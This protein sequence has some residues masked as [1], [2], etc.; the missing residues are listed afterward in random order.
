M[1]KKAKIFIILGLTLLLTG[2]TKSFTADKKVY[3][4]NILCLPEKAETLKIYDDNKIDISKLSS[5]DEFSVSNTNY[6][7]VW[8]TLFVNPLAWLLINIGNFVKSYGFSIILVTLLLRTIVMPVTAKTAKQSENMKKARPDLEAL[9]KKYK[10][11][12]DRDS[13]MK[14]S[15]EQ[16]ALYKKHEIKPLAGCL[17]AFIQIPLFFA[18]FEAINRVPVLF[19][20]NFIGLFEL[21]RSPLEA[22]RLGDYYYLIFVVLVI[23]TTYFSFKLNQTASMSKEQE[24]QMKITMNIMIIFI[25]IMSFSLS[26][27]IG[28]Y[29][30]FNSGFTIIQNL[31]FKYKKEYRNARKI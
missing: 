16:M 5:C 19:E 1:N 9:E 2:C 7:G 18:F 8:N 12:T 29:W 20:E 3:T 26:T 25:S 27:G 13:L 28:L 24:N 6:E 30:I 17:F 10:N 11:L 4:S 22:I 23:A 14:K 31:F 15:Q 21:R